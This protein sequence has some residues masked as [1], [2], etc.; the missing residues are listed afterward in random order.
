MWVFVMGL[1]VM[2]SVYELQPSA[3]SS[4]LVRRG[5]AMIRGEDISPKPTQEV[6]D[7][8]KPKEK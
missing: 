4:N 6:K 7:T 1:M 5:L 2:N 3:V 8:Q